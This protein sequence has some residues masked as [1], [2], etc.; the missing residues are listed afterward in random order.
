MNNTQLSL[1]TVG[2]FRSVWQI[3]IFHNALSANEEMS[4]AQRVSKRRME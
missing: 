4:Q 2:L 3:C 1:Q